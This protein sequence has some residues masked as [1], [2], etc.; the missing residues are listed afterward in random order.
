MC[1]RDRIEEERLKVKEE[2]KIRKSDD[3]KRKA[4]N[5]A[6]RTA[7]VKLEGN[8]EKLK[9]ESYA[10]ARALSNPK[11]Y[12][13]EDKAREY[14]RRLKEIEKAILEL[15]SQIKELESQIL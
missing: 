4:H 13:D 3:K 14:G 6:L 11:F 12:Q 9:I 7:I 8:K 2:E 10:K 5:A 15:D 1:I